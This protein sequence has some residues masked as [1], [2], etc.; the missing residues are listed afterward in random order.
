MAKLNRAIEHPESVDDMEEDTDAIASELLD[1]LTKLNRVCQAIEGVEDI[2]PDN[3]E[4]AAAHN[5]LRQSLAE[6]D[7]LSKRADLLNSLLGR[8][9]NERCRTLTGIAAAPPPRESDGGV[10]KVKARRLS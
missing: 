1:R 8:I 7:D 9:N 4:V 10:V 3:A 6:I 5:Q 2:L